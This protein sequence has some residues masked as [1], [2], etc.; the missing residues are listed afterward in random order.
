MEEEKYR[1]T[2]KVIGTVDLTFDK[3]IKEE[4]QKINGKQGLSPR[5]HKKKLTRSKHT[6]TSKSIEINRIKTRSQSSSLDD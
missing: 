1:N 5:G 3:D 4:V 6:T 2:D